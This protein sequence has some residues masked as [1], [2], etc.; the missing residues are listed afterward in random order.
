MGGCKALTFAQ[1]LQDAMDTV[2]AIEGGAPSH[3]I[4]GHLSVALPRQ[5]SPDLSA[6][7]AHTRRT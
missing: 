7:F 4:G 3:D 2:A 6:S 1:A 5:S